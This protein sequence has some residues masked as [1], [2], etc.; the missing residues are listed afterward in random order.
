MTR[1]NQ[2]NKDLANF[3]RAITLL[4]EGKPLLAEVFFHRVLVPTSFPNHAKIKQ[5]IAAQCDEVYVDATLDALKDGDFPRARFELTGVQDPSRFKTFAAMKNAIEAG[6][7]QTHAAVALHELDQKRPA[8]AEFNR[9]LVK[10]PRRL[11]A[12]NLG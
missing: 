12:K 7:D 3:K 1:E 6:L 10:D 2:N 5:I 4:K 9:S 11:V 8:L